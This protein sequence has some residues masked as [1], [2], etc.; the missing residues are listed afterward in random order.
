MTSP[1]SV[2]AHS[3]LGASSAE[4]WFNCPGSVK[5]SELCP[6][7][8]TS[9]FAALGTAA[10]ELAERCLKGG[11]DFLDPKAFI[12][13]MQGAFKIDE[14]MVEAVQIYVDHVRALRSSLKGELLIEHKFHLKHIHPDLYGTSDAVIRQ[15]FGKL[16]V[17]D[18]KHGEGHAV[19]VENN[20][21]LLYYALGAAMGGDFDEVEIHIVQPRA[22]H[23]DGPIRSY[24]LPFSDLVQWGKKL[25]QKAIETQNENAILQEGEHC[26]YCAA[27][28]VCPKLHKMA[29]EVARTDFQ[30][31]KLVEVEKLSN[32]QI[33][34]IV[35]HYAT[36]TNWLESVKAF[37]LLKLESGEKIPGIKLVRGRSGRNWD[38]PNTVEG[39]L[40]PIYGDKIFAPKKL[41]TVAQAEKALGAKAV[42]GLWTKYEGGLTVAPDSDKRKPALPN[43]KDD[44]AALGNNYDDF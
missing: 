15:E 33:A 35:T 31:D 18:Y 28:P 44:F 41:L 13:E 21:Q 3:K 1:H 40:K 34:K 12:G 27:A 36:V 2:R 26:R 25:K 30:D 9:E 16:I 37:A 23:A 32:E 10:H 7:P 8:A 42:E 11:D 14:N 43:A 5:L 38:D 20:P 29:V 19:E 4:R 24:S 39:K 17:V 6:K 22:Y